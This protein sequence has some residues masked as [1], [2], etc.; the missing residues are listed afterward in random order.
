MF[1][2]LI[3]MVLLFLLNSYAPGMQKSEQVPQITSATIEIQPVEGVSKRTRL[4]YQPKSLKELSGSEFNKTLV[5]AFQKNLP[6]R[7]LSQAI[8]AWKQAL[9]T[10]GVPQDLLNI[11]CN[12]LIRDAKITDRHLLRLLLNQAPTNSHLELAL[13]NAIAQQIPVLLSQRM[14]QKAQTVLD[15]D[16]SLNGT[17]GSELRERLYAMDLFQKMEKKGL[18]VT[19]YHDNQ[20][21]TIHYLISRDEIPNDQFENTVLQAEIIDNKIRVTPDVKQIYLSQTQ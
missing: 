11:L 10:K 18:H 17:I 14:V 20:T 2:K 9:T 19:Q 15:A 21:N 5:A 12:N 13:I 16:Q 1:K 7:E 4:G 8:K 6:D 3:I